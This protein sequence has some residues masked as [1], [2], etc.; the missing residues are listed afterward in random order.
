[1]KNPLETLSEA[2]FHDRKEDEEQDREVITLF[3]LPLSRGFNAHSMQEVMHS[4]PEYGKGRYDD[5]CGPEMGAIMACLDWGFVDSPYVVSLASS[6]GQAIAYACVAPISFNT[7]DNSFAYGANLTYG[8]HSQHTGKGLGAFASALAIL[9]AER[10]WGKILASG[11]L[12]VQTRRLNAGSVRLLQ[13]LVDAQECP[14]ACFSVELTSG[15]VE[16]MGIR[17][18]W[19]QAVQHATDYLKHAIVVDIPAAP[20]SDIESDV[21]QADTQS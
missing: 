1:M 6:T 19:Q 4:D 16:F 10:V 17:T 13:Q 7:A 15:L 2:Y 21:L 5:I 11:V 14:E 3:S 12:N 9:Q 20:D 8:V 18:P